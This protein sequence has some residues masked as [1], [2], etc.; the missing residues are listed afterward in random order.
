[1]HTSHPCFSLKSLLFV[2][3][4]SLTG[5]AQAPNNAPA[6]GLLF[7]FNEVEI[8]AAKQEK[9]LTATQEYQAKEKEIKAN[10]ALPNNERYTQ[11]TANTATI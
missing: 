3:L 10:T 9:A 5:L 11:N 4:L 7:P 6:S 1:M 8:E 2:C